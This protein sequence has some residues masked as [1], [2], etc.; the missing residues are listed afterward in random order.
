MMTAAEITKLVSP[1]NNDRLEYKVRQHLQRDLEDLSESLK[2]AATFVK[3]ASSDDMLTLVK[4]IEQRL[5]NFRTNVK[6]TSSVGFKRL[7]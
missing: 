7:T 4:Q 1:S 6:V 2:T 5:N 3:V